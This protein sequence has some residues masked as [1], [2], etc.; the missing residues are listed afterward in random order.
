MAWSASSDTQE[1]NILA[2]VHSVKEAKT[3]QGI[4]IEL[5]NAGLS[6]ML[7]KLSPDDEVLLKGEV[8]YDPVRVDGKINM[9][10]KFRIK[11]IHP[12]SLKELGVTA[13]KVQD[14][15]LNFTSEELNNPRGTIHV[16]PEVASAITITAAVLLIQDL[17]GS[18]ETQPTK[19]EID[20]A[21]FLSAGVLATGLFI[22]EMISKKKK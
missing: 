9:N 7:S 13:Y 21:T 11:S 10:P 4:A 6:E 17:G 19:H 3:Q 1:V 2:K 12:V 15:P 16:T 22:W 5:E 8:R 20:R 14:P 18:A